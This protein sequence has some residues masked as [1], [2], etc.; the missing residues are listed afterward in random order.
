MKIMSVP[1]MMKI[2]HPRWTGISPVQL[3]KVNLTPE[4]DKHDYVGTDLG[5]MLRLRWHDILNNARHGLLRDL[6]GML[7]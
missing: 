1:R 3:Y 4:R 2:P 6:S 7:S 5:I